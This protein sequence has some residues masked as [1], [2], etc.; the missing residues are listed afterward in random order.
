MNTLLGQLK[1]RRIELGLKQHDMLLRIG[2]SRQQY[3]QLES[4]GN[5]RLDTLE[6][7]AKGLKSRVMLIPEER[8]GTVHAV[9]EGSHV[10]DTGADRIRQSPSANESNDR[11]VLSDDPWRNVLGED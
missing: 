5:P 2:I 7:V 11:H 3:Q 1:S 10:D 8:L 6:L 9:L 4:R